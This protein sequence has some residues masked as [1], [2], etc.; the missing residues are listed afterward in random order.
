[1]QCGRYTPSNRH[2]K[3]LQRNIKR[4]ICRTCNFIRIRFCYRII[5]PTPTGRVAQ[6]LYTCKNVVQKKLNM[7]LHRHFQFCLKITH[8]RPH[9]WKE[10]W[11]TYQLNLFFLR[12]CI[13]AK[14]V[15]LKALL[16]N[17]QPY[18]CLALPLPPGTIGLVLALKISKMSRQ[19]KIIYRVHLSFHTHLNLL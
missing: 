5:Q 17:Y 1:M 19:T 7:L 15:F 9:S 18:P 8:H 11:K 3:F 14:L 6:A 10:K 13:S 2:L 16:Q 4:N 12:R